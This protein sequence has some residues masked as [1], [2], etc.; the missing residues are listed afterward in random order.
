ML[1]WK[2]TTVELSCSNNVSI[3]STIVSIKGRLLQ[4]RQY[5]SKKMARSLP[6]Y[7]KA[8]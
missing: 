8:V 7:K 4:E 5:Q 6:L 3:G 2:L 1:A